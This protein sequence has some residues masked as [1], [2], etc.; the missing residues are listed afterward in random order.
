MI[1]LTNKT[2]LVLAHGSSLNE[3]DQRIEEFRNKN[4]IVWCGMNYF[5]PSES[6][7]KKIGK[8]FSIVFDCST[9]KNNREYESKYRLPRLEEYLNRGNTTYI[10]LKTGRD[11]LYELR[12]SLGSDFNNKYKDSIIYAEDIGIDPNPFC[13]SL[14]LYLACLVKLGARQ[15]ILLGADGGGVHGNSV[16]SYYKYE[17]IQKDKEHADNT[18]YNMVGDTNNVNSSFTPLMLTTLGYV[19]EIINCSPLSRYSIF[20][21]INYNELIGVYTSG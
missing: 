20:K 4:S 16:E 17:E 1:D 12:N 14:H 5:N 9:V 19:P 6:I 3:L 10:S 2:C 13:V 18:S 8:S 15:I 11:N 7:L 21:R